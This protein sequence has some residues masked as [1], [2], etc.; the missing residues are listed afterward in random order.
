MT[1][2]C[3]AEWKWVLPCE[4][5]IKH[6]IKS[7]SNICL[8]LMRYQRHDEYNYFASANVIPTG[9][10]TLSNISLL[11]FGGWQRVYSAYAVSTRH[12]DKVK[13]TPNLTFCPPKVMSGCVA[14]VPILS[15]HLPFSDSPQ[16][17]T[18]LPSPYPLL[19]SPISPPSSHFPIS[20]NDLQ[21]A[22]QTTLLSW[23]ANIT[24]VPPNVAIPYIKGLY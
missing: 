21:P 18:R 5:E 2:L 7:K 3:E 20:P 9:S 23:L 4:E 11:T 12:F 17:P 14:Q 19:P 15:A 1:E 10:C 16:I 8:V 13:L 22:D 24:P 6:Y